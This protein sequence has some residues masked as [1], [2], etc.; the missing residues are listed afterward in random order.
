MITTE[1]KRMI[2]V[3]R[4]S[5]ELKSA[6][7][8]HA[9]QVEE[10]IADFEAVYPSDVDTNAID[11]MINTLIA[12]VEERELLEK[13]YG[14]KEAAPFIV[15]NSNYAYSEARNQIDFSRPTREQMEEQ[16]KLFP[17]YQLRFSFNIRDSLI[18]IRLLHFVKIQYADFT[19]QS[20]TAMARNKAAKYVK[21]FAQ[22]FHI[23]LH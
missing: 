3:I 16:Q 2:Y 23:L 5:L 11:Y 13:Y 12:N 15:R 19:K 4:S 9:I 18:F 7:S 1:M 14:E 8:N 20:T 22:V 21:L 10:F 6:K 17:S